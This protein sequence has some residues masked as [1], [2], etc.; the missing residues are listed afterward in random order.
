[1]TPSASFTPKRSSVLA[2]DDGWNFY[3]ASHSRF[4]IGP[5]ARTRSPM[6]SADDNTHSKSPRRQSRDLIACPFFTKSA[7]TSSRSGNMR[8]FQRLDNTVLRQ[9]P[10]KHRPHSQTIEGSLGFSSSAIA[11]ASRLDPPKISSF[12]SYM[13]EDSPVISA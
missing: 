13:E 2:M 5:D 9:H 8:L 7:L 12:G 4:D 1:M 3:K 11:S 6:P 10:L